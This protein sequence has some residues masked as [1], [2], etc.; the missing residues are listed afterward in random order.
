MIHYDEKAGIYT[1]IMQG[2]SIS[3][4]S[5]ATMIKFAKEKYNFNL[6]TMLN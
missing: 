3:F 1:L 5:I 6:L 2:A 4:Y